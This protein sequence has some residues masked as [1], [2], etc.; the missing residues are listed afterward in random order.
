LG[1]VHNT[2]EFLK[3]VPGLGILLKQAQHG[4]LTSFMVLEH[5]YFIVVAAK[6]ACT[7]RL[8]FLG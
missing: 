4:Q 6:R 2:S 7:H 5:N 8:R 3:N 1:L